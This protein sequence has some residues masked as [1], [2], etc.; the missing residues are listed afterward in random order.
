M[1]LFQCEECGC[2][3]NTACCSYHIKNFKPMTP[4]EYMDICF[5]MI[6]AADAVH[7]LPGWKRSEGAIAEYHYA[8]NIG[9]KLICSET[10][11]LAVA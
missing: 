1:S 6:R 10:S 2:V 8:K 5:A 4:P 3:E 11:Q 9:L 7:F